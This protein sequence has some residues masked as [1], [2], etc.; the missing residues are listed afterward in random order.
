MNNTERLAAIN[1]VAK[2]RQELQMLAYWE[3]EAL[4]M[5]NSRYGPTSRNMWKNFENWRA[6]VVRR[7]WALQGAERHAARAPTRARKVFRNYAR[8]LHARI[9]RPPNAGGAMVRRVM[10]RTNVGKKPTRTVGTSMSP[11]RRRP[12][13]PR[14]RSPA[15]PRRRSPAS[16]RRS[17][18]ANKAS[19]LRS[20]LKELRLAISRENIN[21]ARN[22]VSEMDRVK[23]RYPSAEEYRIFL[24]A[25]GIMKARR[26]K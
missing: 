1:T 25:N 2:A 22:I 17:P 13:S 9:Y 3:E 16:P 8:I 20:L 11:N 24:E 10:R 12:A 5:G 23:G 14:R 6:K 19:K 21:S 7:F 15:S 26:N 18:A 4:G